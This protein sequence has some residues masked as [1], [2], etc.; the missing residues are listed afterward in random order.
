MPMLYA[1]H[2]LYLLH[3]GRANV[4]TL[5]LVD[6]PN[7]AFVPGQSIFI[8]GLTD[9]ASTDPNGARTL[10]SV[11]F[12]NK[13]LT[14]AQT[15]NNRSFATSAT[16]L[17]YP[18][19]SAI[20][21]LGYVITGA[22]VNGT[23]NVATL[24]SA[25]AFDSA[26]SVGDS[27]TVG[28]LGFSTTDPNGAKTIASVS[29]TTLTYSLTASGNETYTTS[30]NSLVDLGSLFILND[31]GANEV[32]GSGVFSDPNS[33]SADDIIFTATNNVCDILRLRDRAKFKVRYPGSSTI[34]GRCDL[35][36]AFNKVYIFR[37]R[38][39]AFESTPVITIKGDYFCI[40]LKQYS[41]SQL[42]RP[43][44]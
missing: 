16:S 39:T 24:T 9:F 27:I 30:A 44:A 38:Q 23:S 20:T 35:L 33:D 21:R 13:Q 40:T 1:Y 31:D 43:R 11:S 17:A 18:A 28:G 8:E 36:Q 5:T 42:H 12:A 6:T 32:F 4:V 22:S 2:S 10:A 26:F 37:G 41:H 14:F 19:S 29:G 25:T 3:R 34:S 15:G 7:T